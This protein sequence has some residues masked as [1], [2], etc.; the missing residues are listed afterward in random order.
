MLLSEPTMSLAA[1]LGDR[2]MS[3][4]D[5]QRIDDAPTNILFTVKQHF[6]FKDSRCSLKINQ[7]YKVGSFSNRTF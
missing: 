4:D 5:T 6:F 1:G 3:P 2:M 7:R